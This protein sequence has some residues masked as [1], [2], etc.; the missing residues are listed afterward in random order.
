[1][2]RQGARQDGAAEGAALRA[3]AADG[4]VFRVDRV[5]WASPFAELRMSRAA[6]ENAG[7]RTYGE[8]AWR[9]PRSL[10]RLVPIVEPPS[11]T[12]GRGRAEHTPRDPPTLGYVGRGEAFVP[13]TGNQPDSSLREPA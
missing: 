13:R 11:R 6:R 3:R 12:N 7:K 8:R 1:M 2:L 10:P 5:D 4:I 9:P